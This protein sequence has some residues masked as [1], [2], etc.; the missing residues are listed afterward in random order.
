MVVATLEWARK[1]SS[2]R[3]LHDVDQILRVQ[4]DALDRAAVETWV[5]EL[6]LADEWAEARR[7]A[8][9]RGGSE[10]TT[11][12]EEPMEDY[13]PLSLVFYLF[14]IFCAYWAQETD[15]S[16]LLWFFLGAFFAP[17]TGLVLLAKNREAGVR[18]DGV[19][20]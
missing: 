10:R 8:G 1:G 15:R 4:G 7:I 5:E 19:R 9:S 13:A 20:I 3:Q 17:L 18:V 6:G 16:A 2:E 14:G 12:S 11:E